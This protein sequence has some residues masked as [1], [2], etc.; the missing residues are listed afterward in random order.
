MVA[1]RKRARRSSGT[2][3]GSITWQ[4]LD[5]HFTQCPD[6][7]ISCG[8]TD[9]KDNSHFASRVKAVLIFSR[10]GDAGG[11]TFLPWVY[12]RSWVGFTHSKLSYAGRRLAQ[13]LC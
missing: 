11:T 9:D 8:W 2:T 6:V 4:V 13:I 3:G 1:N 5:A 7:L 12:L 10:G